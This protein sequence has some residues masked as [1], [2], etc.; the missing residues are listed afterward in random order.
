MGNYVSLEILVS[1]PLA[2][3]HWFRSILDISQGVQRRSMKDGSI[4]GY[5]EGALTED[6]M[7]SIVEQTMEA[8]EN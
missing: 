2:Y 7:R 5:V 4:Y 1:F 3:F 8:N 6:L